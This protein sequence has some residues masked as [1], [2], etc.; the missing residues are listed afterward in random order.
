[1]CRSIAEGGRRCPTCASQGERKRHNIRRRQNRTARKRIAAWAIQHHGTQVGATVMALTPRAAKAWAVEQGA[2]AVVYNFPKKRPLGTPG[3]YGF[4]PADETREHVTPDAITAVEREIGEWGERIDQSEHEAVWR[5]CED[6][7]AMNA[8]LN[9]GKPPGKA[10]EE[11]QALYGSLDAALEKADEPGEARTV[12]RGV[13]KPFYVSASAG[14]WVA[15][16][17]PVGATLDLPAYT[18]TSYD[19]SVAEGWMP[20]GHGVILEMRT[21]KGAPVEGISFFK[22]ERERLLPRG[23]R[24]RVVGVQTVPFEG[25]M[26]GGGHRTV[27]QIVDEDEL[28]DHEEADQSA[29]PFGRAA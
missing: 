3:D 1:M 7:S 14:E 6:S 20:E 11:M 25:A 26:G 24:W 22:S 4:P 23:T 19:P 13:R 10:D 27:V 5:Y 2:P 8:P 17:F 9:A 28:A 29:N 12:Y 21:R 16:S 15:E 18:S